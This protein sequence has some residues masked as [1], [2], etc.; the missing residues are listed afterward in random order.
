MKI[1]AFGEVMMRLTPPEYKLIEQTTTV[2]LSFN[3]TGVNILSG[4]SHFGYQT[5]L[6]TQLPDNHV[7]KAAAGFVRKLGIDDSNIGYS[8]NHI[9]LYFLEMGYGN[10]PSE[11]TYL[12]RLNSAFGVSTLADYDIE[13]IIN[14]FDIIHICGITLSLGEGTREA[15]TELAEKAHQ[16]GKIVCFDF[17]FRPSLNKNH[18]HEWIKK[19]YERILPY[20][21]V[22]FGGERDL[23]ELLDFSG[24]TIE[25][26]S[27]KFMEKYGVQYFSGSKRSKSNTGGHLSGFLHTSKGFSESPTYELKIFDRIGTGDAF[28][29]GVITGII[30]EWSAT[31]TVNFAVCNA[32]LA[33][34][35]FGDSPLIEKDMVE[36]FMNNELNSV[37]R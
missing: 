35:T 17:N 20:C 24:D 8:G 4:L 1:L 7:G 33:H 9:G 23:K 13:K 6:L 5:S 27:Q 21:T 18:S 29:A 12:E 34:T 16:S 2:D 26:L 30:E 22:V 32:V 10:R 25:Q 15:A 3:G 37:I 11:V 31:R 14:E 36:K 28:A 19:Q